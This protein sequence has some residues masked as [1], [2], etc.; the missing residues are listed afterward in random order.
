M[1]FIKMYPVALTQE[2]PQSIVHFFIAVLQAK[3]AVKN[4]G[5]LQLFQTS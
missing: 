5:N 4:A 1:V 3:S 2:I